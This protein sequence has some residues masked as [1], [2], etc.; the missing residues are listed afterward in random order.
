MRFALS[1][2]ADLR[3]SENGW[4]D[5]AIFD[6]LGGDADDIPKEAGAYVL[7]TADGTMLVYPWGTSPIYYIGK[8][9]ESTTLRL[10]L[11]RRH[12]TGIKNAV[13]NQGE[14]K[15]PRHRYGA[16]FGAQAVWYLAADVEPK[17]V[18]ATLIKAFCQTYGSV[19]VANQRWPKYLNRKGADNGD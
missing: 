2:I 13:N 10:R 1:A 3:K 16:A 7:G 12:R 19:P 6:L 8:A 14:G 5:H 11:I 17:E 15:W 9:E 4:Y 18:E